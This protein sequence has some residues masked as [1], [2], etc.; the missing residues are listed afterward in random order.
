MSM[1]STLKFPVISITINYILIF[2]QN[3]IL[4]KIA[5]AIHSPGSFCSDIH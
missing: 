5:N 2:E 1:S 3:I 4:N